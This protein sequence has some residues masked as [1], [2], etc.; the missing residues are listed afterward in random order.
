MSV[1]FIGGIIVVL[2]ESSK[3]ARYAMLFLL[4]CGTYSTYC[5]TYA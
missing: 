5:I 2:G 3:W 4:V 1:G